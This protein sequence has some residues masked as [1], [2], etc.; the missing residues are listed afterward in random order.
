[1]SK[2]TKKGKSIS[3]YTK[4]KTCKAKNNFNLYKLSD[5]FNKNDGDIDLKTG[6]KETYRNWDINV[7]FVVSAKNENNARI[8]CNKEAFE[9]RN[10]R[11]DFW[12]NK[13]FTKCEIIG[14]SCIAKEYIVIQDT[15]YG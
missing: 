13:N 12:I 3:R 14:K 9:E 15:I 8:M 2:H 11:S 1:M 4:N 10:Y 7:N 6:L 5:L